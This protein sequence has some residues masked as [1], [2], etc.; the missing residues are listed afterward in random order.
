MAN[1]NSNSEKRKTSKR[2]TPKQGKLRGVP[3]KRKNDGASSQNKLRPNGRTASQRSSKDAQRRTPVKIIPLGGLNEIGKNFTVIECSNDMFI[4]DCGLAFPDSEMLGVDIVIPDFTYVEKNLEKLRGVV[5]T[6]G[7]ED[8]IGGL[9]YFLKKFPSVP[10]YGTRLTI[11]LI[12]GKLREHELLG[13]VKLNTVTP[14]QTIRMGCMA[15]EFIRVNHSIPDSV[16]MAIHTPAGVLI[17]TGDFKVDYTPIEGGIIDLP[18]FAELGNK[19]VLALMSDSTN[20]ERPGYTASERKVGDNLEMLF[21]KAEG[22]RIIIATFAS[23]IH[24]VQQIINNAVN[25]GRKVAVSGR[26][27]V[28]V[29]SV[30][31]ELGYLKVPDG[32]LIDID[33][34]GRYLP[35]QIVLVTTGSQGEPMSAL[36][37]MSMNEHRKVSITPQDFIIISANP[38]P[39]NEKLVTRVVNDLMKLGAEVVYEKMYEVHVSGHACQEE[40]KLMLSITKPKFFIPVHGEFKHLMKHKQTAMTVG[41]PE[42]NIIIAGIGDVIETDGVDMRITG[43]VPAGKVLVDG[44]G[45]GDVG[46]IVL[47]DRKHLA[48]DGLIIA[49]AT[50]DRSVGEILSG[51]D[52][53]S[54]GFV[55]VRESEE[56]MNEAKELLTET[57]QTC[58]D[59]NMHEWNAIKGKM[60]DNLS[61][62]IFRRTK[63]SPMILPIIMEI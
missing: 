36:S 16:G 4:I 2:Y 45:V 51:P 54:R 37:R 43:E 58:L 63:R 49:V 48:E 7:H 57:L 40:Q 35:E 21:A 29:I 25:T 1:N 8:H 46:A 44:L 12:E 53:V 42:E 56:L 38:I 26:S 34:I 13:S 24:R 19:G 28:N 52:L 3:L 31:I 18:R 39:G 62:F 20:S 50:I 30:G 55:Y 32:V 47:R 5:I 27:M 41:I 11:G 17:H 9:P 60:K 14:R 22:K 33:M 61:D 23:N 6:H 59:N 10:V 15:V